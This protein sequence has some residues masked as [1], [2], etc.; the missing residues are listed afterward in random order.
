MQK[1]LG[2][3]SLWQSKMVHHCILLPNIYSI[4]GCKLLLEFLSWQR[5]K[6]IDALLCDPD[7]FFYTQ[8]N[9]E[10]YPLNV[11]HSRQIIANAQNTPFG[12]NKVFVVENIDVASNS[13]VNALLKIIEEPPKNT[14]FLLT[15]QN[16]ESVSAT[17]RSRSL[18]IDEKISTR[19][20]F[21]AL[22]LFFDI[23]AN[24]EE[25]EIAGFDFS[26][27]M[28]FINIK[29]WNM[30]NINDVFFDSKKISETEAWLFIEKEAQ[31]KSRKCK[32]A[33]DMEKISSLY[34][35]ICTLQKST[36]LLNINKQNVFFQLIEELREIVV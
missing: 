27:Y 29:D 14:Y 12:E 22:C 2:F 20:S 18:K 9:P 13:A 35:K 32:N 23:D 5:K 34:R 28:N 11:E 26:V 6:S 24:Y 4:N 19:E 8:F 21:E 30:E 10:S 25:F 16:L 33:V 17:V 7:I 1:N 15:Y 31:I 3:L 36:R